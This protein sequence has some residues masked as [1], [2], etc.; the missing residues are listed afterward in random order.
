MKKSTFKISVVASFLMM[1]VPAFAGSD[2]VVQKFALSN[3][4]AAERIVGET[5]V[6]DVSFASM[7]AD[8]S[9]SPAE[10]AFGFVEKQG[11][12]DPSIKAFFALS[13]DSAA[14]RIVR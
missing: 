1:S 14:E 9:N 3:D 13:N 12:V 4:S 10:M 2:Y 6:G 7:I 11:S 5:S 8:Q